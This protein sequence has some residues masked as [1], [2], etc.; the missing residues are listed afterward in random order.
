MPRQ[1]SGGF[2]PATKQS[3]RPKL[4]ICG[5]SL[6]PVFDEF[7]KIT[8][9]DAHAH[10]LVSLTMVASSRLLVES[11]GSSETAP[12]PS[13]ARLHCTTGSWLPVDDWKLTG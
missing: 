11:K 3:A 10:A 2:T 9:I 5:N 8:S 6:R 13:R 4:A 7:A 12:I 1:P